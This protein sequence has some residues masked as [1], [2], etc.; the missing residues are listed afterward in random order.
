M[1][2]GVSPVDEL[3][4][5][6]RAISVEALAG[7]PAAVAEAD[8]LSQEIAAEQR[9]AEL[10]ALATAEQ[11]NRARS[12]AEQERIEKLAAF[13]VEIASTETK[14]DAALLAFET[15]LAR[16]ATSA[17]DALDADMKTRVTIQ[18]AGRLVP[19]SE[20][21]TLGPTD[22]R[23]RDRITERITFSMRRVDKFLLSGEVLVGHGFDVPLATTETETASVETSTTPATTSTRCKACSHAEADAINAALEAKEP[24]RALEER[25]G[26]S[27][28]TLSRHAG[29]V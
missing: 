3:R 21:R 13:K 1:T 29:H 11:G 8:Q 5:R 6:L 16:L 25:Y 26:L 27:R 15:Q 12:A 28:S 19:E 18:A 20:R 23:L 4:N 2:P 17:A 24:L 22:S 7:D 10:E 9:R 14:R